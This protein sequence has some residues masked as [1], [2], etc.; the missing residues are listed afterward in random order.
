MGVLQPGVREGRQQQPVQ[1]RVRGDVHDRA[2]VLAL[3]VE[4]LDRAGRR[5][6]GGE[7]RGPVVRGVELEAQA[8]V[9]GEPGAERLE[10]RGLAEP[11]GD[12]EAHGTRLA[13]EHLV[14]G[15]PG[16]AQGEVER[17]G[18]V[19]P[20]AVVDRRRVTR[21]LGPQVQAGEVLG[22]RGERPGA[23]SGSDGPAAW[24]AFWSSAS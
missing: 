23:R 1:L 22:E 7:L 15:P 13:P 10:R 11:Q 2:L 5:D 19:G 17:G 24:R 6:L 3:E 16:L 20:D 8:G 18:L 9:V 14:Q 12:H 21:R 4:A